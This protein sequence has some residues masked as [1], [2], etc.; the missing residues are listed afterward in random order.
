VEVKT[1]HTESL[2]FDVNT[3]RQKGIFRKLKILWLK[4]KGKKLRNGNTTIVAFILG[5]EPDLGQDVSDNCRC[6]L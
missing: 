1:N 2:T 5:C 4:N 6:G 3:L